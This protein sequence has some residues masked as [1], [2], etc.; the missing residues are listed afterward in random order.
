MSHLRGMSL[1][2]SV[3]LL[4]RCQD[5]ILTEIYGLYGLRHHIVEISED[6]TNAGRTDGRTNEQG[7]TGLWTVG[8]LSFAKQQPYISKV[9]QWDH[10]WQCNV[11]QLYMIAN[12]YQPLLMALGK[13][14]CP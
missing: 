10:M 8:W 3:I 2:L 4:T 7:K 1:Y 11:P 9:S 6:V 13:M 12:G 14:K 5:H